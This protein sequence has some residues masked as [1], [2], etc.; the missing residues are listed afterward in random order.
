MSKLP[1]TLLVITY[2]EAEHIARC[3]DSVP[4]AAEKIV[5]DS[6]ST[7]D[8]VP[9]AERH[10]AR[11]IKQPWLGFGAQRNFASTQAAHDWILFLD[12]DE[13]LTAEL[14]QELE[15][16]LPKLLQSDIA[17]GVLLR[18]AWFMGKPLRWYRLL[19]K[20]KKA[21]L[22]HRHRA[23]WADVR[24][25]E[26]LR[27]TGRDI[28][29]KHPFLHYLNPTLA[30]AELKYLR[31]SELKARDWL[32]RQRSTR[33]WE[34]PL[35]FLSTFFKDYVLRLAMLDGWRGW[36]AA[37]SAA[38]YAVYKRIRYYEMCTYPESKELADAV[39]KKHDLMR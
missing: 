12:A 38:N 6:G 15:Q 9:I 26:S 5:I 24:V 36:I 23:Q 21:R 19:V 34:W 31:Y 3:L 33:P 2:N 28:T 25:H 18:T 14:A 13:A 35:V 30:H 29:F 17:A 20:E 11:V 32:D 4:F 7:D 16:A 39:L 27:Y 10:G 37:Y 1:I 22:Y 8:T